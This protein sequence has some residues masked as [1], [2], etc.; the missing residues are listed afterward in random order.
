MNGVQNGNE[1]Y[2][3]IFEHKNPLSFYIT[4]TNA[5]KIYLFFFPRTNRFLYVDSSPIKVQFTLDKYLPI[6][7][8]VYNF[9]GDKIALIYWMLR[10]EARAFSFFL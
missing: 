4:R 9:N 8:K 5:H 1:K 10:L 6:N 2:V 7:S 3:W